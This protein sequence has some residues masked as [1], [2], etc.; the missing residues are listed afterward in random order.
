MFLKMC[1]GSRIV[2]QEFSVSEAVVLPNLRSLLCPGSLGNRVVRIT[3]VASPQGWH[4]LW[5]GYTHP[6]RLESAKVGTTRIGG[7]GT[8]GPT[9]EWRGQVKHATGPAGKE[10]A[11]KTFPDGSGYLNVV[12]WGLW[13]CVCGGGIYNLGDKKAMLLN[14]K[15]IW[16]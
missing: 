2:R 16:S 9:A 15:I 11:G 5:P 12:G 7:S 1:V 6:H 3:L 14:L 10:V 13:V 8:L 4:C